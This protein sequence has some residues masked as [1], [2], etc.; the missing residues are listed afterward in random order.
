MVCRELCFSHGY[1]CATDQLIQ[2][3]TAGDRPSQDRAAHR[4]PNPSHRSISAAGQSMPLQDRAVN[5]LERPL[6]DNPAAPR[7]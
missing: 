7:R 5:V 1:G 6:A 2:K 4:R 3:A